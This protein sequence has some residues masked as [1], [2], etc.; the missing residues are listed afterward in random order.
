MRVWEFD[1][2]IAQ[3]AFKNTLKMMILTALSLNF[4]TRILQTF[5]RLKFLLQHLIDEKMGI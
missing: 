4:Q 1:K 3:I 2:D 5:K